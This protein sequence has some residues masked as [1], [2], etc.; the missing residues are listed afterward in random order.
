MMET[1]HDTLPPYGPA[2][3]IYH[4]ARRNLAAAL[5]LIFGTLAAFAVANVPA[6]DVGAAGFGLWDAV[7][8]LV[9][10]TFLASLFTIMLMYVNDE[11]HPRLLATLTVT[12][13][14][15]AFAFAALLNFG[16]AR[17]ESDAP[18]QA[19]TVKEA[20]PFSETQ[21]V[22]ETQPVYLTRTTAR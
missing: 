20:Q 14:L 10:A 19:G 2:A 11:H 22:L 8:V 18:Q 21:P 12:M 4:A 5:L 7:L 13:H 3:E 17:Q 9:I 6:L 15:A 16:D 1:T